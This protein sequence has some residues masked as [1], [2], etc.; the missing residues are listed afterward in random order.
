MGQNI[1]QDFSDNDNNF[2]YNEIKCSNYWNLF[3]L[4]TREWIIVFYAVII[5]FIIIFMAALIICIVRSCCYVTFT[6]EE[7]NRANGRIGNDEF[8]KNADKSFTPNTARC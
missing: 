6:D 5:V 4:T 1:A 8:T 2:A 3:T 7:I